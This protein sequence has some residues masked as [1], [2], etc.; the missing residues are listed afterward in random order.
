MKKLLSTVR[1][2]K[3]T[4][5]FSYLSTLGSKN[6]YT[7]DHKRVV[8]ATVGPTVLSKLTGNVLIDLFEFR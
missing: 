8:A 5:D 2:L 7:K 1:T 3:R 6:L 4:L